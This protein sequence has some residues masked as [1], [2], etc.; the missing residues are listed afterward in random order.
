MAVPYIDTP[1]TEVDANATFLDRG[2]RSATRNNLSVLDELEDSFQS[3][4][5]DGDLLKIVDNNRK[6]ENFKTPKGAVS[7]SK[8]PL[9]KRHIPAFGNGN[10]E[11]TPL[12]NSVS[13]NHLS[14]SQS[15]SILETPAP[16]RRSRPIFSTTPGPEGVTNFGDASD[17][18]E[19][20]ATPFPQVAGSSVQSSPFPHLPGQ[21]GNIVGDGQMLTLKEQEKV[22]IC[23]PYIRKM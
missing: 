11:F 1:R 2:F 10:G 5:K 20:Q 7:R 15:H 9:N 14:R 16:S 21:D 12:M 22:R 3:P 18:S 17:T 8:I 4:S 13:K 19:V 6:R 23:W